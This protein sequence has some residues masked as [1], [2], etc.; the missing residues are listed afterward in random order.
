MKYIMEVFRSGIKDKREVWIENGRVRYASQQ[1]NRAGTYK[2]AADQFEVVPG[3][4][5]LDDKLAEAFRNGDGISYVKRLLLFGIT[6]F[7]H[8]IKT[9]YHHQFSEKIS[10]QR[11][12]LNSCPVDYI[13]AVEIPLVKLTELW[14]RKLRQA[15]VP[16]VFLAAESVQDIEAIPWQRIVEAMFPKRM[17]IVCQPNVRTETEKRLILQAWKSKAEKFR[18]NTFL[19]FP[20]PG[21]PVSK[22]LAQRIGL[23]PK[24]GSLVIGSDADYVMYGNYPQEQR[25][26]MR[27]PDIIVLK[28]RVV[29]A[30]NRWN[31]SEAAGEELTALMPEKFLPIESVYKYSDQQPTLRSGIGFSRL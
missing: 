10:L 15:A 6:S 11:Q 8:L 7:I 26:P 3:M 30:G 31:F 24:K 2:L 13:H 27:F 28:G 29:K 14:I 23:F 20:L 22:L 17:L 16:I 1:L 25:P 18:I 4:I 12:L 5:A 19:Q 21:Q 9:E